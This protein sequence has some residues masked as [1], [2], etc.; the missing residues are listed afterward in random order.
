M[1]QWSDCS[2]LNLQL[3]FDVQKIDPFN[4]LLRYTRMYN[5]NGI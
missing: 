5:Y 3:S 2:N 1:L 4:N